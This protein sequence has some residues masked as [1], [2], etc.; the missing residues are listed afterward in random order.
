MK[1]LAFILFYRCMMQLYS[2]LLVS[3]RRLNQELLLYILTHPGTLMK[4]LPRRDYGKGL[5]TNGDHLNLKFLSQ[6]DILNQLLH[7][8]KEAYYSTF[9]KENSHDPTLLFR[10]VNKLLNKNINKSYPAAENNVELA[11]AFADFFQSKVDGIRRKIADGRRV[12]NRQFEPCFA[13]ESC[14]SSVFSLFVSLTDV[15]VIYLNKNN[16]I[17]SCSLDALTAAVMR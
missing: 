13:E 11:N 3:W 10:S 16:T 14:C 12:N 17:K 1:H 5:R 6:C 2:V 4:L 8:T 9:I 7:R 15:E